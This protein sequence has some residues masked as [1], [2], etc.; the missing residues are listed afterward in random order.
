MSHNFN[1]PYFMYGERKNH[2]SIVQI[3]KTKSRK[4]GRHTTYDI[5]ILLHIH[6]RVLL[7]ISNPHKYIA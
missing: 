6:Y 3:T 1:P 4:Q 7:E 2:V 5:N